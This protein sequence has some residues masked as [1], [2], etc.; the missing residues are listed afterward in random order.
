LWRISTLAAMT[1]LIAGGQLR[2]HSLIAGDNAE[3]LR[4]G[5]ELEHLEQKWLEMTKADIE[6]TSDEW[7][8]SK[9]PEYE[10]RAGP[11][12][13]A[14]LNCIGAQWGTEFDF[15]KLRPIAAIMARYD[16]G[17]GGATL[18]G[19]YRHRFSSPAPCAL[20]ATIHNFRNRK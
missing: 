15:P 9:W 8:E 6:G 16:V 20:E 3:V 19:V 13:D 4:L 1:C 17:G 7:D 14:I 10:D 12:I 11:L 5:A 2:R 18:A